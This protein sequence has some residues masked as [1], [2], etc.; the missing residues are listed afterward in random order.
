MTIFT[1]EALEAAHGDSLLIHYGAESDPRLMVIDGGPKGIYKASL[2]PRL[3]AIR[4]AR[5]G[6]RLEVR[7]LLVSHIDDD[8]IT[9]ILDLTN[10]LCDAQRAG[11]ALPYDILTL[12]HNSF[13]DL[14]AKLS[15]EVQA[16]LLT[17]KVKG[18]RLGDG[19]AITVSV[20]QGRQLR[21]NAN[22]LS[23]NVNSGFDELVQFDAANAGPMNMGQGLSFT[24]L[25]PRKA[26]LDDLQAQWAKEV[27]AL[28]KKKK[29]PAGASPTPSEFEAIAAAF[30]DKSIPNLSSIVVLAQ[31]AG[32]SM[33]LTGDARGDFILDS[34]EDAKLLK[35]GKLHV[36]ILKAPHHGSIR[37]VETSFFQAIT[38]DHYV[39]SANGKFDNPDVDTFKTLF[40][41]RPKGRYT[42]WLTNPVTKPL[43][44]VKKN[45]PASVLVK[46]RKDPARSLLIEL[47]TPVGV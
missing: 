4:A 3:K 8:H 43:N 33:L 26:E 31:C 44:F 29:K 46:V 12:W 42:L 15:A 1:L 47:G 36:D 16:H 5:G 35:A 39:F 6:G 22:A 9:G 45:K 18:S 14:T 34:L 37:N 11:Q 40:A 24:V 19:G 25:G 13:D 30:V 17:L 28:L 23:L 21:A 20:P 7:L 38:A 10:E 27:K 2:S 41:A 32:K